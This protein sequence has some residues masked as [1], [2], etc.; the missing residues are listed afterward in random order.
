[1]C[2]H[3]INVKKIDKGE[4]AIAGNYYDDYKTTRLQDYKATRLQGYKATRLQGYKWVKNLF[5]H[6]RAYAL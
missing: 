6:R 4:R 3:Y 2:G 5:G 1:M